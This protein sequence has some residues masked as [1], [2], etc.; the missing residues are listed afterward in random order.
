MQTHFSRLIAASLVLLTAGMSSAL[1]QESFNVRYSWRLKG[2]YAPFYVAQ[3]QKLFEK[4]GLK[5]TLGEGAGAPAALAGLLQGRE[6]AVVL[7]AIFA[8]TAISKGMPIKLIA[9]YQPVIPIAVVSFP[10]NPVKTPKDMEGK[11]LPFSTGDTFGSYLSVFCRINSID[12]SKINQVMVDANVRASLFMSKKVEAIATYVNVDVPV[13]QAESK[14][15]LTIMEVGNFGLKIPGLAVVSSTALLESKPDKLKAFLAAV[16][17]AMDMARANPDAAAKD[18]MASWPAAP[19]GPLVTEQVKQSLASYPVIDGHPSGWI[20][21]KA[22][23]ETLALMKQVGEIDAIKPL[24]EYYTNSL[25]AK[26]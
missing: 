11:R 13:L 16:D 9:L 1:A 4:A 14:V 12:C 21:P 24:D 17:K 25:F 15:P 19:A 22:L 18:L 10:D 5:V 7:P 6:D 26:K 8:L 3:E 23:S 2:E 20:E